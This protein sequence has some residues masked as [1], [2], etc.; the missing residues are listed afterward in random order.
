MESSAVAGSASVFCANTVIPGLEGKQ[1]RNLERKEM[2]QGRCGSDWKCAE[3]NAAV[4]TVRDGVRVDTL[5][6]E[7]G[8]TSINITWSL[9][10][11]LFAFK[12]LCSL[13]I[14]CCAQAENCHVFFS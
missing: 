14:D 1:D 2:E 10:S 13:N 9:C 4:S 6:E 8:K 5:Q 11:L 7:T 3:A 12:L